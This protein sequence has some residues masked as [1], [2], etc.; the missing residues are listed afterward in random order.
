MMRMMGVL[1]VMRVEEGVMGVVRVTTPTMREGIRERKFN[2]CHH[3]HHHLLQ[4]HW[5]VVEV[6]VIVIRE[7]SKSKSRTTRSKRMTRRRI[8]S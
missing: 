2:Q 7:G 3:H 6:V 5:W 1:V 8:R 4:Y